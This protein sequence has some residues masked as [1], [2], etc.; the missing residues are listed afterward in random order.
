MIR[1][2]VNIKATYLFLG[3]GLL[4]VKT[5]GEPNRRSI[6]LGDNFYRLGGSGDQFARLM[7]ALH[8]LPHC[9]CR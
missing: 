8:P 4:N 6:R 3:I 5:V 1:L 2:L 7:D 9:T